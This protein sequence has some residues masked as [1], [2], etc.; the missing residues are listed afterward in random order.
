MAMSIAQKH[1]VGKHI[2]SLIKTA[3]TERNWKMADLNKAIG[4]DADSNSAYHW[5]N[6]GMPKAENRVKLAQ[7]LGISIEEFE[8]KPRNALI[9]TTKKPPKITKRIVKPQSTSPLTFTVSL[10]GKARIQL[11]IE[12]PI[13]EATELL[14][15]L[16]AYGLKR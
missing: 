14:Q 11:D 1:I 6:G 3:M 5:L 2:A 16:M 8:P 13:E 9:V 12:L 7:A 10:D 4:F 15:A